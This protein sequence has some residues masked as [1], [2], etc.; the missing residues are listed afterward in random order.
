LIRK[1]FIKQGL[2]IGVIGTV[3]GN[4]LA[5]LVSFMLERYKIISLP[6]EIYYIDK[7][8]I[9]ITPEIFLIVS[10]STIIITFLATL[11]PSQRASKL[12]PSQVLRNE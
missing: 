8:P 9:K 2:L 7:I 4:I 10:A 3:I 12:N 6:E 5:F 11:Y 1:I